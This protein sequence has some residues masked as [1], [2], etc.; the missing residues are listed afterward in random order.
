MITSASHCVRSAFLTSSRAWFWCSNG[1]KKCKLQ[2]QGKAE[3]VG[4]SD[5]NHNKKQPGQREKER[6]KTCSLHHHRLWSRIREIRQRRD[7]ISSYQTR[8][9]TLAHPVATQQLWG[10]LGSLQ[11]S[12]TESAGS[13]WSRVG[14]V[15]YWRSELFVQPSFTGSVLEL[16]SALGVSVGSSCQH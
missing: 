7:S 9:I 8:H 3:N 16:V 10:S 12:V 6:K 4:Q 1:Q 14:K 13:M 11:T 2:L 15:C 5:K